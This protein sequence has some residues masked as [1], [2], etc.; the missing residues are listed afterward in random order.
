MNNNPFLKSLTALN[1]QVYVFNA[2]AMNK[3][4]NSIFHKFSK[5]FDPLDLFSHHLGVNVG[6]TVSLCCYAENNPKILKKIC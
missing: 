3:T 1:V 5:V 6:P 2:H 4:I